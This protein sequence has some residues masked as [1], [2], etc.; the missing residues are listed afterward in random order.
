MDEE[1]VCCLMCCSI[2]DNY[3]YSH[4]IDTYVHVLKK[5]CSLL[6]VIYMYMY[7]LLME[8]EWPNEVASFF[9]WGSWCIY[10]GEEEKL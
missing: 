6:D 1:I 10:E 3:M 8:V 9:E 2:P 7:L 5:V 4:Q